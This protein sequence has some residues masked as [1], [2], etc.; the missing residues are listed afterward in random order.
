[1]AMRS[2]TAATASSWPMTRCEKNSAHLG[3]L[4]LLAVVEHGA[5]QAGAAATAP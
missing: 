3:E 4:Y 2:T 1:M 5:R